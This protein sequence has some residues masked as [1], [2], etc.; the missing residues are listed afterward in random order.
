MQGECEGN[1]NSLAFP[2]HIPTLKAMKN[3][4]FYP[5]IIPINE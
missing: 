4:T 5:L 2:F 1:A 3:Q